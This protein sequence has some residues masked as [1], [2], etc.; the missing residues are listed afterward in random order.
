[1]TPTRL[2]EILAMLDMTA[3][4]LGRHTGYS[5]GAVQGWIKGLSPIPVPISTWLED[6]A[7][8]WTRNPPPKRS[9]TADGFLVWP[10][11]EDEEPDRR[12]D[13]DLRSR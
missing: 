10:Q 3:R 2:L 5:Y 9:E 7:S 1:L 8:Y 6:L 4:G 12:R 13:P 11:L